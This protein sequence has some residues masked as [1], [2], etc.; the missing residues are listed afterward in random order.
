MHDA[1]LVRCANGFHPWDAMA[2]AALAAMLR[3][4]PF[5]STAETG[6]GGSTIVLSHA[7]QRR[8]AFQAGRVTFVEGESKDTLPGYLFEGPLDLVLLD[9]PNAYPLHKSNSH[10]CSHGSGPAGSWSSTIFQI[11]SVHELADFLRKE[12]SVAMEEMVVRTAFFK[13]VHVL[14]PRPDRWTAQGMNRRTIWR[15]SWRDRL[16]RAPAARAGLAFGIR[17]Q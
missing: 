1:G 14:E 5:E 12:S 6:C 8:T 7:S 11:P 10:I 16:R 13:R 15:D 2:P 3:R 9:G 17:S 4:G